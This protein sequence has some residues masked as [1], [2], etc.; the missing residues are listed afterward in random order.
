[1]FRYRVY[2]ENKNV[3]VL[4]HLA[5]CVADGYT[6]INADGVWKKQHEKSLVIE[7]IGAKQL[8]VEVVKLARKIKSINLQEAVLVTSEVV[9]G[10][11]I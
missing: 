7:F 3:R 1:M 6:V 11:L 4:R 9:T 10:G 8:A 2:T 5:D